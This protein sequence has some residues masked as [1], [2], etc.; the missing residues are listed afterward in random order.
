MSL[1]LDFLW[2]WIVLT[3]AVGVC[4]YAW[5]LNDQ[6]G[7]NLIIAVVSPLLTLALGLALYYGVDTD[8]K[9][10]VR[11]LDALIA[12]VERDDPEA[13]CRFIAPKATEVQSL[14]RSHMHFVEIARAK[15]H[16]LEISLNDATSPPSAKVQFA[17]VFYWKTKSPQE[18]FSVDQPIPERVRF[19]IE[20]VQTKDRSWLL[21]S[22]FR[23]FPIRSLP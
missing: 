3:F 7:R 13:V 8:R 20:L 6:R 19:E 21:T 18:G 17:A 16:N 14:A 4:G 23:Y 2:I 1:F 10:I 5:Y 15:Y 9:S 11:M 12:A 22:K